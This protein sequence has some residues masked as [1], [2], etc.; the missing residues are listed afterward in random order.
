MLPFMTSGVVMGWIFNYM[1]SRIGL[2]T[3]TLAAL[4]VERPQ[5]MTNPRTALYAIA[6]VAIW[7]SIGYYMLLL[8]VGLET[9]PEELYDAAKV[10]GASGWQ[11]F[12][13]ITLPLLNPTIV[14]V[15]VLAVTASLKNFDVV[16][17][18]TGTGGPVNSTLT[19][20]LMVFLEAFSKLNMGRAAA[21]TLVFFLFILIITVIQLRVT[22][23]EIQY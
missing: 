19:L 15:S 4:G 18:M 21:M 20:P 2:V 14:L 12:W 8:T 23:R 22:T 6:A 9:I 7:G 10:D 13:H 3:Q 1:Y 17:T 5:L 16:R 11:L